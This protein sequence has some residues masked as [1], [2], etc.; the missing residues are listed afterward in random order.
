[1]KTLSRYFAAIAATM[2]L[3]SAAWADL[4]TEWN[5]NAYSSPSDSSSGRPGTTAGGGSFPFTNS[6]PNSN[7]S[8]ADPGTTVFGADCPAGCL[9]NNQEYT[10]RGPNAGEANGTRTVT[11]A[12]STA[13]VTDIVFEWD[14]VAGYRTSKFYQISA[15]TDGATFNPVSGGVGTGSATAGVGSATIDSSG[16]ITVLF[17]DLYEPEPGLDP[18]SPIDYLFDLSYAFASGSAFENNPNFAVRIAA[19]HDPAGGDFVSSFAGTT[20]ADAVAG[21]L[22]TGETDTRYDLASITGVPEPT[23]LALAACGLAL[24]GLRRRRK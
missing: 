24:A 8:S 16:L 3:T 2:F 19:I 17:D 22:R 6:L 12:V 4:A 18:N 5:Y 10:R 1:M 21:Y 13:G 7:G 23:A 20:S 9:N 15:T 14:M 11:W